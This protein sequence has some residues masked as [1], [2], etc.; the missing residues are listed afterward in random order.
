MAV[1]RSTATK[2]GKENLWS[3][4]IAEP[5]ERR[6]QGFAH[7]TYQFRAIREIRPGIMEADQINRAGNNHTNPAT[8]DA[9]PT[10]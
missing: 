3:K 6:V 4:C 9:A 2:Y 8:A 10:K 5:C 1:W 7:L